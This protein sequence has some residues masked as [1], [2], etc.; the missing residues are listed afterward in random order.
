[1]I[2]VI[3]L[4]VGVVLFLILN[5]LYAGWRGSLLRKAEAERNDPFRR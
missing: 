2:E 4:G 5:T 3:Y 1:M